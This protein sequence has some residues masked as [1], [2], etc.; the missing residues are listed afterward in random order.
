MTMNFPQ[1]PPT[2]FIFGSTLPETKIYSTWKWIVSFWYSLFSGAICLVLGSA[3][4][5]WPHLRPKKTTGYYYWMM[6]DDCLNSVFPRI[7]WQDPM[8]IH[9]TNSWTVRFLKLPIK[10]TVQMSETMPCVKNPSVKH[11]KYCIPKKSIP[12]PH[13]HLTLKTQKIHTFFYP[14]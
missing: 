7:L 5:T 8:T 2:F 14:T 9:P 10:N 4:I 12:P 13:T 1:Y 11:W 3:I 6:F